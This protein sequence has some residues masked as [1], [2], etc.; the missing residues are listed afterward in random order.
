MTTGYD[1]NIILLIYFLQ[2]APLKNTCEMLFWELTDPRTLASHFLD[3]TQ[4]V[5]LG[6]T[7][8]GNSL[9][10]L[11]TLVGLEQMF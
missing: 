8:V 2:K 6:T 7:L 1:M 10:T 4:E 11:R 5:I 3:K 9:K